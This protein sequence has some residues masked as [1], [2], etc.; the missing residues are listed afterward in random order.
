ME[1]YTIDEPLSQYVELS[2]SRQVN[3]TPVSDP[4]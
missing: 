3:F 1:S 4:G 2:F